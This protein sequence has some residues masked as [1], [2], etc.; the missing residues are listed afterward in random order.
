VVGA[1]LDDLLQAG[2]DGDERLAGAGLADER[3]QLDV[4]VEEEVE[5]V[6]LLL[7]ARADAPDALAQLAHRHAPASARV[8]ARR[9]R[10]APGSACP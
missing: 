9:A 5:R 2:G 6:V 10:C 3:D 1:L 7:V 8:P 4:V